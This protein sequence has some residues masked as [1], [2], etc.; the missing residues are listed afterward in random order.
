MSSWHRLAAARWTICLHVIQGSSTPMAHFLSCTE[1]GLMIV[2]VA[3]IDHSPLMGWVSSKIVMFRV[4]N[5]S[6]ALGRVQGCSRPYSRESLFVLQCQGDTFISTWLKQP[7]AW[8][9]NGNK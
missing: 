9:S 7:R 3:E 6:V 8:R 2:L 4:W 1:L 5:P